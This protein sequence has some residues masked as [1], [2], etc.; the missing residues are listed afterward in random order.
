MAH[1]EQEQFCIS[2]KEKFPE[3]FINVSVLDVGSLNIN[4]NNRYLFNKYN[5][6]GIDI[7]PGNN[8]DVICKGHKYISNNQFDV[9]ISTECFEHDEFY[10]LTIKNM[11]KLLKSGGLMLFTCATDGRAEHGTRNKAPWAAP[12]VSCSTNYYRNLTEQDIRQIMDFDANFSQY[13][14]SKNI[15]HFDLYFWGIKI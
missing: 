9:V 4:G 10:P 8:V 12:F 3:K 1:Y 7:G 11:Y 6:I 5:Y 2:V 15:D 14:F 13:E